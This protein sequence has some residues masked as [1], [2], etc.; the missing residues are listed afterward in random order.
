MADQKRAQRGGE[1]EA[2]RRRWMPHLESFGKSRTRGKSMVQH[3]MGAVWL[4]IHIE[5]KRPRY[6][7]ANRNFRGECPNF[8]CIQAAARSS[9]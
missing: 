2:R 8:F 9:N 7:T 4:L 6:I 5:R 1:G 3:K